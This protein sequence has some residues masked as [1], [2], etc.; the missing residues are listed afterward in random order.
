MIQL[1]RYLWRAVMVPTL[2]L[3]FV[4]MALGVIDSGHISVKSSYIGVIIGGAIFGI[5]H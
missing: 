5:G 4:L 3:L 1:R 2:G